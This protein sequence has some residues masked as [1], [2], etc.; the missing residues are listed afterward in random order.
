MIFYLLKRAG[1]K[2]RLLEKGNIHWFKTKEAKD[3]LFEIFVWVA[4]WRV[5]KHDLEISDPTK[6]ID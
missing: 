5:V 1:L 2:N 4:R 6:H 3:N